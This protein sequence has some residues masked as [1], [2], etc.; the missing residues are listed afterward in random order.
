MPKQYTVKRSPGPK[1]AGQQNNNNNNPNANNANN[2][3]DN[4]KEDKPKDKSKASNKLYHD[5][6]NSTNIHSWIKFHRDP[7]NLGGPYDHTWSQSCFHLDETKITLPEIVGGEPIKP[8]KDANGEYDK[9][10]MQLYMHQVKKS[11][12][13]RREEFKVLE[14]IQSKQDHSSITVCNQDP[15]CADII[16]KKDVVRYMKLILKTHL[17]STSNPINTAIIQMRRAL[18]FR[19]FDNQS[20]PDYIEAFD[21]MMDQLKLAAPSAIILGEEYQTWLL[22]M[23]L[24]NNYSQ[25]KQKY[26]SEP[27][28]IPNKMIE[29][30]SSIVQHVPLEVVNLRGK[31]KSAFSTTSN[32]NNGNNNKKN[33]N[34]GNGKVKGDKPPPKDCPHC[35]KYC[36]DFPDKAHWQNN[37]P[38]LKE[39]VETRYGHNIQSDQ[40]GASDSTVQNQPQASQANFNVQAARNQSTIGLG[41]SQVRQSGQGSN[42][43][44][45]I[46]RVSDAIIATINYDNNLNAL[47]SFGTG[48][49]PHKDYVILDPQSQV[50][51]FNREDMVSNIRQSDFSLTLHGMGNGSIIVT[52]IADHPVLG[53]V[54]FH[55]DA[56]INVW[57]MRATE[58]ACNVEL[59]KEYDQDLGCKVTKAFLATDRTNGMQY[60]FTY[61]DN[62][63]VLDEGRQ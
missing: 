3:K 63:Y 2:D 18:T 28:T 4:K 20:L 61:Q 35:V 46:S 8:P 49:H 48:V 26:L 58:A 54:W 22:L 7:N 40:R 50:A 30:K 27:K 14:A 38:N 55:P 45:N 9:I 6:V 31:H 5:G 21:R 43:R 11:D 32:N 16:Q 25:L 44:G 41:L 51:I 12:A 59:L 60:R 13:R 29:M 57:Q 42:S 62:L 47:E 15:D 33:N 19:H 23:G 37:C 52:E 53:V 39:L 36:P 24:S 56:A 17:A 10:E 1:Q 34:G